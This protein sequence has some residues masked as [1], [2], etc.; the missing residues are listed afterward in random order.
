M[1]TPSKNLIPAVLTLLAVIVAIIGAFLGSGAAGGM[2]VDETAG[3]WLSADATP[4]AP[5]GPA[6]SIWSV[7]YLGL[8]VYAL[9]Q[10]LPVARRSERQRL[11]RPWAVASA[12]L[13]ALWLV[14]TQVGQLWLSVLVIL[15]LLAVLIRILLI[16]LAHRSSGVFET[17]VVDGTFGLYLG[18]VCVATAAN[19]SS[20]LASA[21]AAGFSGWNWAAAALLVVVGAIGV[22]LAVFDRGRIAPALALSWGLA[23]VAVGRSEGQFESATLVWTAGLVALVVLASTVAV[24]LTRARDRRPATVTV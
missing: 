5:A 24:R 20:W 4:I 7:I 8:A 9:W 2:P 13:N 16:L 15:A 1:A 18:W 11:L 12:L 22:S 17:I 19:I 21:G 3:G 23:W 6:F 14:A 10:L